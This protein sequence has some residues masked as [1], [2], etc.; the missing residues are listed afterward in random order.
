MSL[1]YNADNSG[2]VPETG[3]YVAYNYSGQIATG[4][5]RKIGRGRYGPRF[6]IEQ[7]VPTAGHE[8]IVNG[9]PRCVLVLALADGTV[10]V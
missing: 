4:Y 7:V 1:P 2:R 6:Y 10:R 8:S 5:I 9:G 3:D